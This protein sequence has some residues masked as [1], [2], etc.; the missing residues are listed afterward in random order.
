MLDRFYFSVSRGGLSDTMLYAVRPFKV[1]W[2]GLG[3]T[4]TTYSAGAFLFLL[5]FCVE[6]TFPRFIGVFLLG[7]VPL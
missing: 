2:R 1:A 5:N 6:L 3:L 4:P 7:P